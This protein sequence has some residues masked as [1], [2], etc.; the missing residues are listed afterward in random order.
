MP[1]LAE[2]DEIVT[3]LSEA[4]LAIV[5]ALHDVQGDARNREPWLTCHSRTTVVCA[6]WLTNY[7]PDPELAW[8][9]SSTTRLKASGCSQTAEWPQ[10]GMTSAREPAMIF[11]KSASTGGG[12]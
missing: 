8:R 7:D 2:I 1:Q 6:A 3:V 4:T 12:K 9:K 11:W 10:P 5:S